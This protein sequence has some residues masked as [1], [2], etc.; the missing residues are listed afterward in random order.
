MKTR[1]STKGQ[2]VLPQ[3]MRER[4][5]LRAGD[6]LEV[7][8]E[9]ERIVLVPVRRRTR[10]GRIVRDPLTGFP[11]LT[12]GKNAPRLTSKQVADI[13]AE[14]PRPICLT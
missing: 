12:A 2:V 11:V 1:M 8:M 7:R 5:N 13:L 9:G 14:F 4:M 3:P 6:S 10:K